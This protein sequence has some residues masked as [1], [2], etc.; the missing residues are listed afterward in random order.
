MKTFK[1]D[2]PTLRYILLAFGM[3]ACSILGTVS[4]ILLLSVV[5]KAAH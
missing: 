3:V 5:Y 2:S 4:G 1:D